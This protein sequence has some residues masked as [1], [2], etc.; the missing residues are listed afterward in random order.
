MTTPRLSIAQVNALDRASF[1]TKFGGLYERS[2]WV[3]EQAWG[4]RP[5]ADRAALEHAL[6]QVVLEA[7]EPRQLELLRAHP[8]LG[9]RLE[10]SGYSRTEQADVGL[11]EASTA[12]RHELES[13]NRAYE[14]KFGFPFI[15]AV[16]NASLAAILESCR[17]RIE[18]DAQVEFA[19]SLRQVFRIA[20]FRLADLV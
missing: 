17:A 7:S 3:A 19:E 10:L 14:R 4:K 2:P 5:L 8:A 13:L 18:A 9:T 6:Q 15:F 16:R 12:Q 1:V 11:D 20:G